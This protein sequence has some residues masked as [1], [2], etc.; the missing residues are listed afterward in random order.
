[1]GCL[2]PTGPQHWKEQDRTGPW[3]TLGWKHLVTGWEV[4]AR[5]NAFRL[6]PRGSSDRKELTDECAL[7][8]SPLGS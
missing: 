5:G 1:M 2:S 4:T 3:G 6:E 7:V 8:P